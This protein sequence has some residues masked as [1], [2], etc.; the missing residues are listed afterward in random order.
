[1]KISPRL[2][3]MTAGAATLAVIGPLAWLWQASLLPSTY[4]VHDHG[5]GQGHGSHH[6]GRDLTSLIADPSREADVELTLTARRE[7]FRLASGRQVDGYTLNGRSPGPQ[8]TAEVGQLV[9]VTLVNASVPDG[10]TLHWHGIDVP[11][12]MDGVAGVTQDAVAPGASFTYRFVADRAGTFWYH[13]HQMSHEQVIGGLLGAVVVRPERPAKAIDVVA[14]THLYQ[15]VR[16][17]N[18]SDTDLSVP[19]PPGATARVRVINTDNG[20]I[21]M[22]VTGT[23]DTAPRLVAVDGTDLNGPGPV[24]RAAILV[25]SGARADLEVRMPADGSPVRVQIGGPLSVVLGGGTLPPARRPAATLDLL[26]YGTPAARPLADARPDRAFRYE[27][28]R[29]PGFLDGVPGLFWT[30]NGRLYPDIPVFTVAEGDVVRMTIANTSGEVH[31]M[32]LHG[33]RVLV[34]S[35]DGVPATGSPWWTDSLN[36]EDGESYE[37]AFRAGNPGVWADHCHN[38]PHA[39][40][41]LMVHLMYEGITTPFLVG[42]PAG[43]SRE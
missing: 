17:I 19:A 27:I 28:G 10:I 25:T 4:S 11:A 33:H 40:E 34:L 13:S 15:G 3:L 41:G 12:A 31:P 20:P 1:M 43:N 21:P 42:G 23:P 37:V 6:D 5:H 18:G 16:T 30:V 38:L 7:R 8:I 26:T 29:R 22:W 35:R 9:Q 39:R 14:L 32:H 36:V 2:R 24:E